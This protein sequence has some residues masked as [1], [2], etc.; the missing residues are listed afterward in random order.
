MPTF[1]ALFG[2]ITSED[3]FIGQKMEIIFSLQK[4]LLAALDDFPHNKTTWKIPADFNWKRYKVPF[5][6]AKTVLELEKSNNKKQTQSTVLPLLVSTRPSTPI[7]L[8]DSVEVWKNELINSQLTDPENWSEKIDRYLKNLRK[9][10]IKAFQDT[11]VDKDLI[12]ENFLT[13]QSTLYLRMERYGIEKDFVFINLYIFLYQ[14]SLNENLVVKELNIWRQTSLSRL[15]SYDF[16]FPKQ[17]G[18][19]AR[20]ESAQNY[21]SRITKKFKNALADYLRS[22]YEYL[23]LA[24]KKHITRPKDPDFESIYWLIAWNE[25]A[26]S[27]QIAKCFN[28]SID[29]IKDGINL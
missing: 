17:D 7:L 14:F 13:L 9:T 15:T 4:H 5:L 1:N 28:K 2:S 11:A 24:D 29:T 3:D 26:T 6:L 19:W 27:R 12:W 10:I 8:A 18:W 21:Q 22:S 25:G 20:N 23:Q 16:V